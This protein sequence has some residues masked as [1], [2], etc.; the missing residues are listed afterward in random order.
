MDNDWQ[1]PSSSS[2][3]NDAQP[4]GL[5]S[6][7]NRLNNIEHPQ[8]DNM[9]KPPE[10]QIS[11]DPRRKYSKS[12]IFINDDVLKQIVE[13][14]Q[15]SNM[16]TVKVPELGQGVNVKMQPKYYEEYR[17]QLLI[18]PEIRPYQ[19]SYQREKGIV[20]FTELGRIQK[21]RE[22]NNEFKK[23]MRPIHAS[24]VVD[25]DSDID[26]FKMIRLD[27]KSR[28]DAKYL[29]QQDPELQLHLSDM[30]A[31]R[32][33]LGPI[34]GFVFTPHIP[35]Q[36]T[37]PDSFADIDISQHNT[38]KNIWI[39]NNKK[40]VSYLKTDLSITTDQFTELLFEFNK[41]FY[42]YDSMMTRMS[43]YIGEEVTTDNLMDMISKL[44]MMK[45][46][47][48]SNEAIPR[49]LKRRNEELKYFHENSKSCYGDNHYDEYYNFLRTL[50]Q[51][52]ENDV[53]VSN[54]RNCNAKLINFENL[55][56]DNLNKADTFDEYLRI[57]SGMKFAPTDTYIGRTFHSICKKYVEQIN[58]ATVKKNLME[59]DVIDTKP[60]KCLNLSVGYDMI[61][62]VLLEEFMPEWHE[63]VYKKDMER[64]FEHRQL[65][66]GHTKKTML[67]RNC[68]LMYRS[69]PFISKECYLP[70]IVHDTE[71]NKLVISC[72][73][74][75]KDI[76]PIRIMNGEDI[77]NMQLYEPY[78]I[79][80][81]DKLMGS[82]GI[83]MNDKKYRKDRYYNLYL[84][85]RPHESF[86]LIPVNFRSN[87][88]IPGEFMEH[89]RM[90]HIEINT[91]MYYSKDTGITLYF[92]KIETTA[93]DKF[94]I[95]VSRYNM[96]EIRQ[97]YN[98]F[99]CFHGYEKKNKGN[100]GYNYEGE[101]KGKNED[102][103]D[104][105]DDTAYY[106]FLD[107]LK[108]VK[109]TKNSNKNF[110]F[111]PIDTPVE[112]EGGSLGRRA[113]SRRKHT[114]TDFHAKSR[115]DRDTGESP[116]IVSGR[117]S[118]GISG[119]VLEGISGKV[120]GEVSGEVLGE[121]SKTNPNNSYRLNI[122]CLGK[123]HYIWNIKVGD[124]PRVFDRDVFSISL[125]EIQNDI[126][127][128][129]YDIAGNKI[130]DTR[131]TPMHYIRGL[132]VHEIPNK[133]KSNDIK[134][135]WESKGIIQRDSTGKIYRY[136]LDM[137]EKEHTIL[138]YQ[139]VSTL[140]MQIYTQLANILRPNI[141]KK[142][143]I[144]G[145][146]HY[147]LDG[148]VLYG[149]SIL[150]KSLSDSIDLFLYN[151][152]SVPF[153]GTTNYLEMNKIKS[154]LI[155]EPMN[156]D[157]IDR[158]VEELSNID[159]SIVD[160]AIGIN[161]LEIIRYTF[162]FQTYIA[163]IILSLKKMNH[164]GVLIIN[165][166]LIPNKM[167]FD[168]ISYL[169]CFFEDTFIYDYWESELHT[170]VQFIH[171]II[172]FK[173][174]KGIDDTSLN[175]LMEL[176]KKIYEL[177]ETGGYGFN[178]DDPVIRKMFDIP[179]PGD[180]TISSEYVTNIFDIDNPEIQNQYAEYKEYMKMKMLGSIRNFTERMNIFLS[181]DD[182]E[183][184]E[185]VCTNAKSMAIFLAKKYKFPLLDWVGEIPAQYLDRMIETNFKYIGY[186]YLMKLSQVSEPQFNASVT[187]QCT[188]C[189]RLE[190]TKRISENAYLYLEKI[191]F[192]RY[193][194]V[195]L[196]VNHR[197]KQ[198]NK[199]L[200][201]EYGINI[202]GKYVSRAWIKLYELLSDT[203]LLEGFETADQLNVFHIC[204][205]P[206]NFVQS[207]SHWIG[208]N[209]QIRKH[210]WTAQSLRQDMG[211]LSDQYDFIAETKDKWDR[212]PRDTGDIMSREN[213][214][215]YY[216][217]YRGTDFL[218]S[219]CGEGW[220]ENVPDN[221][222]LTI[223]Q[224]FYALLFPR[225]GGG[226]VIKTFTMKYTNLYMA[227][228]YIACSMY[229][230]V[231]VFKSYTNFWSFEIYIVGKGKRELSDKNQKVLLKCLNGL[232][233]GN[234]T[235]PISDIPDSFVKEYEAII[236]RIVSYVAD[237]NKFF[238]F[239]STNI[240]IFNQNKKMI[241]DI[242]KVKNDGWVD[243]Y[244]RKKGSNDI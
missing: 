48:M 133:I 25:M 51:I 242:I 22:N 86:K 39:V 132:I 233:K 181:K 145:R 204:E 244:I 154:H 235:Y 105:S 143:V 108:A 134:D 225:T 65:L 84:Y 21:Y 89:I 215:Y 31:T 104:G 26:M 3:W 136:T 15:R 228:L 163:P 197:Y 77:E 216:E 94:D 222:N 124:E 217:K 99:E 172:T 6:S 109:L 91:L 231:S 83:R 221:R 57:C 196:F 121:V 63:A 183:K 74:N 107:R 153:E 49:R 8:N 127:Q 87:I 125:L 229:E 210:N 75:S 147:L 243:K 88:I 67:F 173:G 187:I 28:I 156:N 128:K 2:K 11:H 150:L 236:H 41:M 200:Q 142:Y 188:Y 45:V 70:G 30:I 14:D 169:S 27:L 54:I 158:H 126:V 117:A 201:T 189:P 64:A 182:P 44:T 130:F 32:K 120:S 98:S 90:L 111:M 202:N 191:N 227:L 144:F 76:F 199:K 170:T 194:E 78:M 13:L 18:N 79:G 82:L 42:H 24:M 85:Y 218:I 203:R 80:R 232:F 241:S 58:N 176:N 10:R 17:K 53:L 93:P 190:A 122:K 171:S 101:G 137:L 168:F 164:G 123:E 214:Y 141:G 16:Y 177:D 160:I 166:F 68:T 179:D 193:K 198:L 50:E 178:V 19:G 7:S 116:D 139:F 148:I 209:T 223:F 146:N 224:M 113:K 220:T 92:Y 100:D 114:H 40:F 81:N 175:H 43:D 239:L 37:E 131:C 157:W 162:I 186:S 226:F 73:A 71:L 174:F 180:R 106:A 110:K 95:L 152:R 219:D 208:A 165:L 72:I 211:G 140:S 102:E 96:D 20:I 55:I 195:E 167:V 119:E 5:S 129:F 155:D 36:V 34:D 184:M 103:G 4:P 238:V 206:G 97:K 12:S 212:G 23:I 135:I 161:D 62:F 46:Y 240:D 29:V 118:R 60:T 52:E 33:K 38:Y 1:R 192:D 159:Y 185:L 69:D 149:K 151:Y 230:D 115:T 66:L 237:I 234:T 138:A 56:Y 205:A 35:G 213:F 47:G 9:H 59:I 112:Q 61:P 207:M